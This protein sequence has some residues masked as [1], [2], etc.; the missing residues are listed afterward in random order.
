M[1]GANLVKHPSHWDESD[2]LALIQNQVQE[3]LE[4][5]YKA[6]ASL[7]NSEGRKNEISKDV[8]SFANSA[9]GTIVYGMIENGH[10]P[11]QIDCGFDPS[12]VTKEW[13][14]QVINSRIQRRIDGIVIN[15][16]S[17]TTTNPGHVAYAISI[18]QSDRAPHMASDNKF[19]KRFN[20]QSV[21]MEEYEV[22][23][24]SRRSES[25]DLYLIMELLNG[26]NELYINNPASSPVSESIDLLIF[27]GNNSPMPAENIIIQIFMDSRI[28][29]NEAKNAEIRQKVNISEA[30]G[31]QDYQGVMTRISINWGGP[32]KM[33]I[34]E[35]VIFRLFDPSFKLQVPHGIGPINIYWSIR[36]PKMSLK[37]GAYSIK[38][39]GTRIVLR[40]L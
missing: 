35:G 5:D 12:A 11:V 19:Y 9:G 24:T 40:K 30:L 27:I 36:S 8:S 28:V 4:L 3:S 38:N 18:P 7:S 34:W 20:F 10:I 26:P 1:E 13:I 17:L 16:V 14:E 23:D 33:P 39:T 2:L 6:C 21:P 25:P 32:T 37:R 31:M 22:R 15:P 29:I